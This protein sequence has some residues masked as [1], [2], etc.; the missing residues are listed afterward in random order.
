MLPYIGHRKCLVIIR[1]FNS[2][3]HNDDTNAQEIIKRK[4]KIKSEFF[5]KDTTLWFSP[6]ESQ[7]SINR[8]RYSVAHYGNKAVFPWFDR[9]RLH[10]LHLPL[11]SS[12]ST[13]KIVS[14]PC[15]SPSMFAVLSSSI[16]FALC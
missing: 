4:E 14:A 3:L 12:Y 5:Q 2:E 8:H 11:L 7:A 16:K 6:N 13:L 1:I 9:N 15:L 10:F